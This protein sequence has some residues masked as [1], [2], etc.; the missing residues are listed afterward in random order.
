MYNHC[1]ITTENLLTTEKLSTEKSCQYSDSTLCSRS[2][3]QRVVVISRLYSW[4]RSTVCTHCHWSS[5]CNHRLCPAQT[6][7]KQDNILIY[8][9]YIK[10]NGRLPPV[11]MHL[12]DIDVQGLNPLFTITK[13]F[14]Q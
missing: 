3:K 2:V 9:H 10:Q 14:L 8:T 11:Q 4:Q 12:Y 7:K 1:T 6:L 5:R 13:N